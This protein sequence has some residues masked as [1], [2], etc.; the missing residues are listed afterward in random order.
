[1]RKI[2]ILSIVL[3]SS[4]MPGFSAAEDPAQ[5]FQGFNLEGFAEDGSKSWDVNGDTADILGA[6]VKLTN[7]D[8]N[9]YG[10]QKMNVKAKTGFLNQTSGNMRLEKDVVI[11]SE[12]GS[13]L[14]TDSL[15]WD[16][17]NDLVTT[18]DK[19]KIMDQ[20]FSAYGQGMEAKPGLKLAQLHK[21]VTMYVDTQPGST[22]DKVVT[23]TSDGPV[24]IDQAV[25]KAKFKDNVV[26]VQ[27]TRTL[28]ADVMEVYFSEDMSTIKNMT[29][30]G[31]VIIIQGENKTTAEKAVYDAQTKKLTLTGRPKLIFLT[32]GEGAITSIGDEKSR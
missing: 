2:F 8:A 29:C 4:S 23:I 20:C 28:K 7:V 18:D 16:R 19:V 22:S 10:K 21:D 5:K 3:L 25:G 32:E 6:E 31:H 13:Q 15:Q 17:N 26:A 1:M 14:V 30:I 9:S 12:D 11:T 27:G 24:E